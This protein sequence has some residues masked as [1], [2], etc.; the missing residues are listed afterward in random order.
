MKGMAM[1]L[2]DA[3]LKDL[4]LHG[5]K[6]KFAVLLEDVANAAY[7]E[8][9]QMADAQSKAVMV[10]EAS[11]NTLH[12]EL[13]SSVKR[14]KELQIQL[15]TARMLRDAYRD[16]PI[17]IPLS[18][19]FLLKH[20]RVGASVGSDLID[21][22]SAIRALREMCGLGLKEAKDSVDQAIERYGMRF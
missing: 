12:R 1:A 5:T 6:E 22:I 18:K 7:Q 16:R 2:C 10:D 21:R 19:E 20:A 9:F 14:E 11:F 3:I 4:V 15:D 8:G 17:V 13:A